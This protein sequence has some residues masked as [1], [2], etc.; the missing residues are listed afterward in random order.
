MVISSLDKKKIL[1]ISALPQK[2]P[3]LKDVSEEIWQIEF[4]FGGQRSSKDNEFETKNWPNIDETKLFELLKFDPDIIH[5]AGHGDKDGILLEDGTENGKSIS[6]EE[7]NLILSGQN[8]KFELI[9]LNSCFS[10][11]QAK[12]LEKHSDHIIAIKGEIEQGIA[13]VF[14]ENFYKEYKDTKDVVK[15]YKN[16]MLKDKI[17]YRRIRKLQKLYPEDKFIDQT[18]EDAVSKLSPFEKTI[19]YFSF[20]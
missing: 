3:Y 9:F 8:K 20:S 10:E 15:S 1:L 17:N 4:I 13:R 12:E 2:S 18:L 11:N 5:F 14:A 7:L 6:A 16:T 19:E